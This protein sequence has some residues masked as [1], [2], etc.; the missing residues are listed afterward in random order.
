MFPGI[1][2][3]RIYLKNTIET[4]Q[5]KYLHQAAVEP[6]QD[7]ISTLFPRPSPGRN[8]AAQP[9]AVD[10]GCLAQVN[11]EALMAVV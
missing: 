7:D 2:V 3:G 5:R 10:I 6:T 8:Q 4:Y 9:A 11:D 1:V